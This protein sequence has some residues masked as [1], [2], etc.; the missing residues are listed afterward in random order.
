MDSSASSHRK[1]LEFMWISSWWNVHRNPNIL[2]SNMLVAILFS[3]SHL[4]ILEAANCETEVAGKA[5]CVKK[6]KKN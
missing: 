6:K 1:G 4:L 3:S 2:F 5:L